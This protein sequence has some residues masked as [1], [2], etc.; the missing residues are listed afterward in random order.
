[1]NKSS[2]HNKENYQKYGAS[3]H[4]QIYL[5]VFLLLQELRCNI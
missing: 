3:I 2:P 5:N 4:K 1:M